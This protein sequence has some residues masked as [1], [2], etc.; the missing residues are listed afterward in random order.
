MWNKPGIR[1]EASNEDTD[2][3]FLFAWKVWKYGFI[4]KD[5][6]ELHLRMTNETIKNGSSLASARDLVRIFFFSSSRRFSPGLHSDHCKKVDCFLLVV[7]S[8]IFFYGEFSGCCL[9]AALTSLLLETLKELGYIMF[10]FLQVS[11]VL[12]GQMS[13]TVSRPMLLED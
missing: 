9:W 10:F 4:E 12:C 2:T 3:E 7:V 1:E 11:W 13:E 8:Q 6:S 5:K